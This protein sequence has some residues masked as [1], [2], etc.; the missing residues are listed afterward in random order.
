MNINYLLIIVKILFINPDKIWMQLNI[1]K[2][3]RDVAIRNVLL[4]IV[5]LYS[6]SF[7]IGQLLFHHYFIDS[8]LKGLLIFFDSILLFVLLVNINRYLLLKNKIIL[9]VDF[10]YFI[11][12]IVLLPFFLLQIAICF[13]PALNQLQFL[14]LYGVFLY[15]RALSSTTFI[16]ENARLTVTVIF[17][18][19]TILAQFLVYY[20]S[21]KIFDSL[22]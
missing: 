13:I 7:F 18:F 21:F 5:S 17:T 1:S 22:L 3:S 20:Y 10:Q 16:L 6:V 2:P 15:W 11:I 9:D 14:S 8:F 12:A 19:I 4:P